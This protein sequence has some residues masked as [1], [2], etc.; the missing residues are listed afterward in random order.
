MLHEGTITLQGLIDGYIQSGMLGSL[1]AYVK[2]RDLKG[3]VWNESD[4]KF[5]FKDFFEE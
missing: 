3:K 2:D 4:V 5:L 1:D